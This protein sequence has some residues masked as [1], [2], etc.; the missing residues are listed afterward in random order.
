MLM[1]VIYV[2]AIQTSTS[3]PP[4][5]STQAPTTSTAEKTTTTQ[6]PTA[7]PGGSNCHAIGDW[8]GNPNMDQWCRENCAV[9]NCPATH[10][11][12]EASAPTEI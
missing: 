2:C 3:A 6:Q 5:T 8:L 12:C 11:R 7:P 9:G 1:M 4:T 10:C